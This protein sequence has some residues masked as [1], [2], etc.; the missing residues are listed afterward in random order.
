[1]CVRSLIAAAFVLTVG[2]SGFAMAAPFECPVQPLEAKQAADIKA[3]LPTG[4]AYGEVDKLN[5]AVDTLKAQG[6]STALVIDNLLASYCPVVAESQAT[7]AQ[8]KSQFNRFAAQIT[9][10]VYALEGADE[11][12]LDVAFPPDVVDSINA[13]ATKAGV[14]AEEWI[15]EAVTEALN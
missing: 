5:N 1:M 9:R 15:R 7:D 3:L 8:K 14:P 6:V 4:D 10:T 13:A 11:I 12:I 2:S